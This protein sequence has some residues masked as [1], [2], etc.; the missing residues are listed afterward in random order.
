VV[1][2]VVLRDVWVEHALRGVDLR[3]ARGRSVA[4]VGASGAGK[5]TLLEVIAGMVEPDGGVVALPAAHG[6]MQDAHLF[7]TTIRANLLLARPAATE[8]E[9]REAARVAAV[10]DW[11]EELPQ[12]WETV[13]G[14]GGRSL[15]GGQR[16][17]IM[18]ARA[19]LADPP[20]L[21]L[22]EPTEGLDRDM[23][24]AVL[25][26][27]L[28]ARAGRTTIVVT[29]DLRC[30]E[31][32]DE[33]VVLDEGRI[34]GGLDALDGVV[35]GVVDGEHRQ[36]AGRLERAEHG[37]VGGDQHELGLFRLRG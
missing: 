6:L 25:G 30:M 37:A 17:R 8:A 11:I 16:Q 33:V 28:E 21:L 9:L 5:S 2:Q 22:D 13:V 31:R 20:V 36:Q 29:H 18:L 34:L 12:A 4:V 32:F 3:V 1:D 24:E 23:A 15:S 7:H 19:L 26:R 14:E 27:V 35:H 10:L